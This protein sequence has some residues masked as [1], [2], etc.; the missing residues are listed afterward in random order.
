M[1]AT[2]KVYIPTYRRPR[3]LRRALASLRAQ[4]FESWTAEVLNDD[5]ADNA[6]SAI[7]EAMGDPRIT[8][9]NHPQNLGPISVFNHCYGP[10]PEPFMSMLEDDNAWEPAF[11]SSLLA[12]L[13]SQPSCTLAW[14][15][16]SIDEEQAEGEVCF[17]G[18]TVHLPPPAGLAGGLH[19]FGS[20][21]QAFGGLH[22]NGAMILRRPSAPVYTTP[23]I[24]VTGVEAW[25]ER[26]MPGPLLYLPEPHARFTLTRTTA[27]AKDRT[28]W[29]RLQTALVATYI[30]HRSDSI[31]A[32]WKLARHTTPPSVNLMI[33][34]ALA[35]ADC[36]PVLREANPAELLR[37]LAG[38]IRHPLC[39]LAALRCR[40]APWWGT[41]D[42]CTR[43]RLCGSSTANTSI[44]PCI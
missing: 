41:L 23:V 16:Q 25:R 17:T 34:A 24:P 18:R 30:R 9:I 22:A 43:A 6:P 12:A 1:P 27:R 37:W 40:R 29:T 8:C 20:A 33:Y 26:M 7:V 44:S 32:L 3:L 36:R 2:V 14:C 15:N 42:D 35:D 4:T 39:A 5:P 13:E 11:L 19:H 31:P 21:A 28:A 10:G 38:A